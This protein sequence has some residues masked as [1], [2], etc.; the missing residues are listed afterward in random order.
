MFIKTGDVISISHNS[1]S[2]QIKSIVINV[3]REISDDVLSVKVNNYDFF[4]IGFLEED[5]AVIGLE[6]DKK[7]YIT[8]CRVVGLDPRQGILKLLVDSEEFIINNRAHERYPVSLYADVENKRTKEKLVCIIKNISYNGLL[9]SSRQDISKE[10]MLN[11]T[12]YSEDTD[13]F[14]GAKIMWTMKK[15]PYYDYGLKITYI[16]YKS[17]ILLKNYI[18]KLKTEQEKFILQIKDM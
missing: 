12:I 3:E 9:L 18:E 4:K 10:D 16:D 14:L 2:L 15:E 1:N 5:L 8:N 11:I 13:I 6:K 7:I 17:Q